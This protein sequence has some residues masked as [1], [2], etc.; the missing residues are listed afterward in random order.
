MKYSP[1]AFGIGQLSGSSGGTTAGRNRYGSYFRARV[2]PVNPATALQNAW[3][4]LYAVI[5]QAWRGLT[6]AERDAWEAYAL[7]LPPLSDSLGNP[8][9]LNGQTAYQSVNGTVKVYDSTAALNDDPTTIVEPDPLVSVTITATAA[10]TSLQVAYTATPLAALTK[11][12]IKASPMVE[13]GVTYI[14]PSLLRQIH[15]SAAAAASPANILAAYEA[16]FGSLV[17]GRKIRFQT[18]VIS[19][20][21]GRSVV[22]DQII[23]IAA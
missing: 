3:R 19:S 20:T 11:L 6:T 22:N 15:V 18:F 14:K 10:I 23:T 16:R 13:G 8:Y 21:G 12:V 7:T 1:S 9:T 2:M 4:A 5:S 17:E